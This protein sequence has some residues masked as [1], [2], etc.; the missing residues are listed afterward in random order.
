ME[1]YE[2]CVHHVALKFGWHELLS[3][4]HTI[5]QNGDVFLIL[6]EPVHASRGS[7]P[8]KKLVSIVMYIHANYI[9]S[10]NDKT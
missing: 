2:F 1:F 5:G 6:F 4:K 3:T 8:I 9:R 7:I 10:Q